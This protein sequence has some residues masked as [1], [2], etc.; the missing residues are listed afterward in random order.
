MKNE[1]HSRRQFPCRSPHLR[2][3]ASTEIL[4]HH[5]CDPNPNR[6]GHHGVR[7]Q[8]GGCEHGLRTPTGRKPVSDRAPS[9]SGSRSVVWRR[10][11]ALGHCRKSRRPAPE[12]P[13]GGLSRQDPPVPDLRLAGRSRSV[14]RDAPPAGRRRAGLRRT[15]VQGGQNP[16]LASRSHGRCGS[17]YA[18]SANGSEDRTRWRSWSTEPRRT[19][20]PPGIT[21]PP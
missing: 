14:R 20:V 13:A 9:R 6:R 7:L 11:R 18:L 16:H 21:R 17:L 8:G 15:R 5:G 1:N 3:T 19:R 4:S 12:Q 2:G 10:K